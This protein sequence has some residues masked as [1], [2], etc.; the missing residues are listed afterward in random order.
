MSSGN[1]DF[2]CGIH[3]D[4]GVRLGLVFIVEMASLSACAVGLLL[5]YIGVRSIASVM[6]CADFNRN[7]SIAR[8]RSDEAHREGGILRLTCIGTS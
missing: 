8:R 3:F 4:F 2:E 6:I 5:V 7:Y 1:E